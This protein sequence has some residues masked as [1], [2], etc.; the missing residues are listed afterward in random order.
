[1]MH[2]RISH[3]WVVA[4][5]LGSLFGVASGRF[6]HAAPVHLEPV[7][8]S[9]TF[10]LDENSING[11]GVG[12]VTYTANA[13]PIYTFSITSGN[14]DTAFAIDPGSGALTVASAVAIDYET[15]PSFDLTVRVTNGDTAEF[16]EGDISIDLNDINEAPVVNAAAFLIAENSASGTLAGTASYTDPDGGQTHTFSIT[17]GNTGNAFAI[18]PDT[19]AVTVATSSTLNYETNPSFSLTIRVTDDGL[20]TALYGESV[21]TINL[22]DVNEV[23]V[24]NTATFSIDENSANGTLVGTV[25]YTDPDV[26]QTHTFS[27]VS[28]N[29]GNAFAIN[30]GTG[31]ISVA[32]STIL[33]FETNPSFSLMVR[34]TDNGVPALNGANSITINLNDVY[35]T[36]TPSITP[37]ATATPVAPT[38]MVISELRSRGPNGVDDEFVE[39]YNPT[40]AAINIGGWIVRRSASCGT[41][42]Y[43]LFTITNNLI[44][45]PGQHF[46]ATSSSSSSITGADQTF[47]P[48][49]ADDGGVALINLSNA[50]IDQV[51]MCTS[52]AYREGQNLAPLAGTANQSYERKVGGPTSCY[53]L[54]NNTGDFSLISPSNP[55]NKASP[56]VMCSGVPTSTPTNTPTNTPQ[57]TITPTATRTYVIVP[58]IYPGVMAINEFLPHPRTDWNADGITDFRD[59]YI[60]VI[61]MGTASTNLKNWQLDDGDGGSSPYFLPDITLLPRQIAHFFGSETGILLGDG[62][63]TVRLIK[64]DGRTADIYTYPVISAFDRTWCRLPDGNGVWGFVCRPSPGKP[65]TRL[66]RATPEP[67]SAAGDESNCLL[68]STVPGSIILAECDGFGSGIWSSSGGNEFWLQ[69]RWKWGVFLE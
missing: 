8:N 4:L 12:T 3:L 51:G 2:R 53:D 59:E 28:G 65:N 68:A 34:V 17:S 20:P 47:S 49:M 64:P 58:T 44:L 45:L 23:P 38:H 61:N 46:L 54:D 6:V 27:I 21:I 66:D 26:G 22:T 41:T 36:P 15:N 32:T 29:T 55:Q 30:A 42:L 63:D 50:I 37:T 57:R 16:G 5:L 48:A 62:G 1:M 52:T 35:E 10:V 40:G 56:I 69:S 60:E 11:T 39:L 43:N 31:A 67:G 19:G 24:V 9:N 18:D 25:P 13:G 33:N 14:T 7:V